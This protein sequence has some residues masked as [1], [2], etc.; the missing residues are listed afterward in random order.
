VA[1]IKSDIMPHSFAYRPGVHIDKTPVWS[2]EEN[3]KTACIYC[4][5]RET[6]VHNPD[7]NAYMQDVDKC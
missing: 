4:V 3:M 1:P 2:K 5:S 6:G 7:A